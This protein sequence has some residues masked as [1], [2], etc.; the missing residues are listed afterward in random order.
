VRGCLRPGKS[1]GGVCI[2]YV[3]ASWQEV[4]TAHPEHPT[5]ILSQPSG[6]PV[7]V[8]IRAAPLLGRRCRKLLAAM[9]W[10]L[11]CCRWY[12]IATGSARGVGWGLGMEL[13]HC[14]H[15]SPSRSWEDGCNGLLRAPQASRALTW[16]LLIGVSYGQGPG[17][18]ECSPQCTRL[19]LRHGF[20][21]WTARSAVLSAAAAICTPGSARYL[22]IDTR[23]SNCFIQW[24]RRPPEDP[25]RRKKQDRS[26]LESAMG[27]PT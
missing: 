21:S 3:G 17:L 27:M 24:L 14:Q 6:S 15:S 8:H 16:G 22:R 5:H 11:C 12:G 10:Q 20:K 18:A 2:V 4:P 7:E 19:V 1:C 26:T 13:S 23:M 25:R 9:P